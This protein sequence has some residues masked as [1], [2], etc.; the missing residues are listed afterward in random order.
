MSQFHD[1]FFEESHEH[2]DELERILMQMDVEDPDSE[3]LD[4]IFRAAHSIKGGSGIFGF[5]ALG[6]VTHV[7][8]HLLDRLRSRSLVLHRD[9]VGL[10]LTTADTLRELLHCYREGREVDWQAAKVATESLEA[11]LHGDAASHEKQS[12]GYGLFDPPML[13]STDAAYG[14]FSD[15]TL[16]VEDDTGFGF[17]DEQPQT[18]SS[19]PSSMSST[20]LQDDL[21]KTRSDSPSGS[22]HPSENPLLKLPPKLASD[23]SASTRNGPT[24][25]SPASA[26][27]REGG[28][29]RVDLWKVDQLVNLVGE[30]VITQSMLGMIGEDVEGPVGERLAEVLSDLQRNTRELQESVMSVRMMPVSFVFNRFPRLARDLSDRL[31][32]SLHLHLEGGDT[33]MDKSMLE[34]LVDPLTHLVRNSIDHGI[35]RAQERKA[36]GKPEVGNIVLRAIQKGGNIVIEIEDDGAG[37]NREKILEKAREK[38]LLVPENPTDA[39]VWK[40]ILLPGFSTADQVTDVSGR[41]VGMDVVKRNLESLGGRLDIESSAGSGS[42]FTIQLPLTLAIIDGMGVKVGEQSFILP[43]VAIAESMRPDKKDVKT[44]AKNDYLISVRDHYWPVIPLYQ[45]ME[46]IPEYTHPADGIVVLIDTGRKRFA[47][48]VDELLG[49]QQVVIKSLEQNYRRVAGVAGATIMGDGCVALI[50]DVESLAEDLRSADFR[51]SVAV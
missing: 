39:Q 12:E 34:K 27:H 25:P 44:L 13:G 22:K 37:L 18:G 47:L 46:A 3:D 43:L 42:R 45:K 28:S 31:G 11:C 14:F 26:S 38:G 15:T 20:G 4:S 1:T 41:G 10:L 5:E 33:E 23:A 2:L 51:E 19:P 8:E 50:L 9:T 7:M 49:Q 48:L 40:L 24:A 30:L 36:Q 32:K 6:S 17:F 16:E 21:E 35:E 29:I